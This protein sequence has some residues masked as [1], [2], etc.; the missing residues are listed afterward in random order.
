MAHAC[1]RLGFAL[2]QQGRTADAIARFRQAAAMSPQLFD[3][4]YHLGATLWWTRDSMAR[5]PR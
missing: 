3:A 1:D 5:L 2:G 4:H